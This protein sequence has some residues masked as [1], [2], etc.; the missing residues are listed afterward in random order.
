M[1]QVM[2]VRSLDSSINKKYY[3][4]VLYFFLNGSI[5]SPLHVYSRCLDSYWS[6]RSG[7]CVIPN[8]A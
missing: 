8:S 4:L 3:L 7:L 1:L 6:H 2:C 5:H